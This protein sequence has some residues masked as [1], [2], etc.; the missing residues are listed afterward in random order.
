MNKLLNDEKII[1][2][3]DFYKALSDYSRLKIILALYKEKSLNVTEI[4]SIVNM[5]Q[6]A[7]SN[8]LKTLKIA[9]IVK[10]EKK[11][12]YMVYELT[13]NHIISIIEVSITH[14]EEEDD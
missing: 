6:T 10:A 7:V 9:N 2:I 13:D 1:Q 12:K 8:Q 11:G 4:M 3:S 5:S 14:M